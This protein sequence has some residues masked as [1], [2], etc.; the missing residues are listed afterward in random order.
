MFSV[1][2]D[3]K[4]D[5]LMVSFWGDFDA[6]QSQKLYKELE[7]ML[8]NLRKGFRILTDLSG[9]DTMDINAAPYIEK[10]M[11]AC[12]SRGVSRIIR[13]IPDS[14]KD[15]GFG[16]MS[17]F[18]Y[19]KNVKIQIYKTFNEAKQHLII[20][21]TTGWKD[22]LFAFLKIT[23]IK[24]ATVYSFR[25]FRFA[26]VCIG[27]ICLVVARLLMKEFGISLGYIYVV[28]IS[29]SGFWFGVSGGIVAASIASIIF[30]GESSLFT[31]WMA[32]EAVVKGTVLRLSVYF[33]AGGIFGCFSSVEQ[34]LRKKLEQLAG[35]DNIT[36]CLNFKF[37]MFSLKKEL[38][39]SIRYQRNVTIVILDIDN[40]KQLNSCYGYLVGNDILKS[41]AQTIKNTTRE[42]DTMGR[43]G[44]DAFVIIFPESSIEQTNCVLERVKSKL[45]QTKVASSYARESIH[46]KIKFST[47]LSS[48]PDDSRDADVL[49]DCADNALIQAKKVKS[50]AVAKF[51]K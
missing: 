30:F 42:E 7:N 27:F 22:K 18:H 26:V 44:G 28:L 13:I 38:R 23:K 8:P 49:V 46:I 31:S 10:I 29:L 36:D 6:H 37:I 50:M 5:I 24:V 40:F 19:S 20:S 16:I 12:N 33:L 3:K 51:R 48:F 17:T 34:S 2:F 14:S 4:N 41:V 1:K 9:L 25:S 45:L 21:G 43:Y 47:G 35:F 15:I 39:R 32:R 11:K